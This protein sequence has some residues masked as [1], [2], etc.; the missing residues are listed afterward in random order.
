MTLA[1][2]AQYAAP[3]AY[4]AEEERLP[5]PVYEALSQDDGYQ[6][7]AELRYLSGE[8]HDDAPD[9]AEQ[10]L[11]GTWS[12]ADQAVNEYVADWIAENVETLLEDWG[13]DEGDV[14]RA[15]SQYHEDSYV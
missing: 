13:V 11:F 3:E 12:S 14:G 6:K 4:E 1:N 7:L 15:Y 10:A 5:Y 9:A 2:M 8:L